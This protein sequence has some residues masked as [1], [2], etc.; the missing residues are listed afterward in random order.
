MRAL[1]GTQYQINGS[2]DIPGETAGGLDPK[3]N[4]GR[5][6]FSNRCVF[7]R[8]GVYQ[9]SA[10]S[11]CYGEAS[12]N[13]EPV[14]SVRSIVSSAVRVGL[15]VAAVMWVGR[16]VTVGEVSAA[17]RASE[18]WMLIAATVLFLG[19]P[20]L[21]AV[22]LRGLLA[23]QDIE[24]NLAASV[25]LA[26]AGNFLNFAAPLGST[27]GDV[28]K[29]VYVARSAERRW[30]AAATVFVDRAIGLGTL[31]LSVTLIALFSG[32]GSRLEVLRG[33]LLPFAALLL[34]GLAFVATLPVWTAR[35]PH[36]WMDAVRR[37]GSI[38]RAV[39]TARQILM[40]PRVLASAVLSTLAIQVLAA[41]A[42]LCVALALG[43]GIGPAEWPA[44]YA[45]FSTGE[46]VKALPGP[47]QGLGTMEMAY[48]YLF[49]DWAGASQIVSAALAIRVVALVCS[50]PG[51]AFAAAWR[52]PEREAVGTGDSPGTERR[53]ASAMATARAA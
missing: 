11:L 8:S 18:G 41:A 45:Y 53:R 39:M 7:A 31:L 33:Y 16:S 28:F 5:L 36:S 25:R 44:L 2:S 21:Q 40:S 1:A 12:R 22:R 37:R 43:F 20:V 19:T 23:T 30:E 3:G 38:L 29:A 50:L 27:T 14:M 52:R 10:S 17:W 47:P 13:R 4:P 48:G 35:M 42:F 34:A 49:A 24:M 32:G 9:A 15:C 51:A 6:A 26:F 46:I